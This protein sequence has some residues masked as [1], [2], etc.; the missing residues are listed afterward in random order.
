MLSIQD[1]FK[2]YLLKS[3]YANYV[4]FEKNNKD[5]KLGLSDIDDF[6][7]K[8]E[9][10]ENIND[11]ETT[12]ETPKIEKVLDDE[13]KVKKDLLKSYTK[14]FTKIWK[15][16]S[17]KEIKKMESLMDLKYI[18]FQKVLFLNRWD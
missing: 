8:V 11:K 17:I 14:N 5:Y 10:F 18:E 2:N 15:D 16:I 3:I 4:I 13:Y 7:S 1:S 9:N 6:S 12:N